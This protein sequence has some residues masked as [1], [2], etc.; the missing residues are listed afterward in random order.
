M[1]RHSIVHTYLYV[2]PARVNRSVV[3]GTSTEGKHGATR[4]EGQSGS[5]SGAG[6]GRGQYCKIFNSL[7]PPRAVRTPFPH[8]AQ[9][10]P[11]P[12]GDQADTQLGI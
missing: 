2:H 7:L 12:L 4:V 1:K 5:E 11:Y 6:A 9:D 3:T 8:P 10:N